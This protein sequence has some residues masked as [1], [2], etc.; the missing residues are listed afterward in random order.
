MKN[1]LMLAFHFPPY[2]QSTGRLRTL[3]LVRHL[4]DSGWR[5][6]I[7]TAREHAYPAVQTESLAEIPAGVEVVRAPGID[8]A[9]GFSLKGAYPRWLATP[10]RW[11]TWA[12]GAFVTGLTQVRRYKPQ[13]VWATFPVP[14]ALLAGVL[15][16]RATGVPL[17]AD[18]RDPIVNDNWPVDPWDRN[19]YA[20]LERW[21]VRA[22][23]LVVVT[24]PGTCRLYRERYPDL[25]PEKFRVIENGIEDVDIAVSTEVA[26]ESADEAPVTL[27]HG[28]LMEDPER[29][30]T[31]LFAALGALRR[32][33]QLPPQGL[34]VV[35]RA[36]GRN[37]TIRRLA[38]DA[39]VQ[40]IV[41][42]APHIYRAEAVREASAAHGLLLF[43]GRECNLQ[44]PAKAY[45]YLAARRPIVALADPGGD[46]HSLVSDIWQSPYTADMTCSE[47]IAG[48]LRR[49]FADLAHRSAVIPKSELVQEY[50]RARRATEFA[51]L[52][53]AVMT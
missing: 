8:I 47:A 49:F 45:E 1:L 27:L 4:P 7:I 3:S 36:T 21:V 22:A 20:R 40:D 33:G 2:A 52:L 28:G 50:S 14:S 19:A 15:L 24:T 39:S 29:D 31:A 11:N 46:T 32:A 16:S 26:E 30:P 35:L 38:Q 44:I 41:T 53:D 18:I 23:R 25:R 17:V 5:P 13:A 34:R 42:V 51:A 12:L 43:Q 9:R 48:V 6:R 37:E 10:D